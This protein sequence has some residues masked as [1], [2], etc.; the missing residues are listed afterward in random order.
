[1]QRYLMRSCVM[2]SA[3]MLLCAG[4]VG[5]GQ[6]ASITSGS[7]G[8]EKPASEASQSTTQYMSVADL[9]E[10]LGAGNYVLMDVRKA[11]DFNKAHI[12]GA[13]SV[14]MDAAKNG[15]ME[16]G[17][18]TM[19][20]ALQKVDQ[21]PIVLICYSGK[22]YAEASTKV[23]HDLGYDMTKVYTLEGGMKSW[24]KEFPDKHEK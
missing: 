3:V 1:M 5:C 22:S 12:P 9:N 14:D 17:K 16:K 8:G 10:K 15:D 21:K 24:D 6:Q 13:I 23:L 18:E 19:R 4:L 2:V 20:A 11:D 7:Q